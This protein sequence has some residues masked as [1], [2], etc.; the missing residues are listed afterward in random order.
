MIDHRNCADTRVFREVA[1]LGERLETIAPKVIGTCSHPRI[2]MVFDWEN[3]WAV[4]DACAVDNRLD[5]RETFLDFFRPLWE[6]GV[7]VD[8][9]DM[10]GELDDYSVVIAPLNYMYKKGYAEKVRAFVKQGG[11][12]V[13]TCWSGEVDDSDLT[14]TGAHPLEDVLGIRTEEIDVPAGYCDNSVRYQG[15]D[16]RITG[17]CG[18]VHA[19]GAKVLAEYQND[20]Y[21][22]YPALTKKWFWRRG[23]LLYR[24]F[25]RAWIF[26]SA[27]WGNLERERIR[28]RPAGQIDGGRHSKRAEQNRRGRRT[29]GAHLVFAKL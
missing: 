19:K 10:E 25:E 20:F 15:A 1:R 3:W 9:V 24:V 11:C 29:D 21:K 16:Y 22:G 4:N 7:D 6:L 12:Y 14:Y 2:T 5:Y 23:G 28:L 26:K 18:L 13:T 8:M 27:L 17:L